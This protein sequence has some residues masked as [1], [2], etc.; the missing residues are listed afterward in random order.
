MYFPF[1]NL[2]FYEETVYIEAHEKKTSGYEVTRRLYFF[3]MMN[4][5]RVIFSCPAGII[6]KY[7]AK[8]L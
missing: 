8:L 4:Y 6:I 5:P 3:T 7:N 2:I 1:T